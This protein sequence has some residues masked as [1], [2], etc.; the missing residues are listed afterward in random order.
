MLHLRQSVLNQLRK[1]GFQLMTHAVKLMQ[2]A[3]FFDSV[4]DSNG[5]QFAAFKRVGAAD[6]RLLSVWPLEN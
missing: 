1:Q 2:R 4:T 5:A 3:Q 6:G